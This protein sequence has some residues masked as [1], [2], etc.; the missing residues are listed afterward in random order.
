MP[1]S[2]NYQNEL[3][4]TKYMS[5][6]DGK[7]IKYKLL[8]ICSHMGS[9]GSFGHYIAYCR[10]KENGKWYQFNDAF[11]SEFKPEEIING[12]DP[13]LLLYEKID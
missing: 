6:N 13:Y 4:I 5:Y 8:T 2:I 7:P 3:D 1:K 11:V 10:H 9:S 12:G